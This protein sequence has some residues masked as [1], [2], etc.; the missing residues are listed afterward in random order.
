[1]KTSRR[2]FIKH[3]A[4][5]SAGLA[6][7]NLG[8]KISGK[9][10]ANVLGSNDRIRVGIVG[11]S[12]RARSTLIPAF[13]SFAEDL[14]FDLVAVS[15]IWKRR[16]D[17]GVEFISKKYGKTLAAARNNEELYEKYHPDAV[18]ISTADFQHAVH[19][20]EAVTASCDVYVE[21]P[22]A[23]TMEDNRAAL[24]AV[25]QSKQIVQIG[26][27]RRSGANYIRANEYIKSGEFGKITMVEMCWNVNEPGRWRRPE[28]V[29]D[30][31]EQDTDWK[32]YLINRPFE[33]WDPRKYVEYRLFW[34]YS[35][36]IPGQWMT[37]QI[38][39]VHWFSG[40]EFPR[41]VVASGGIYMWKDGRKNFDTMTAVFDYGLKDD[42]SD[43][44]QVVYSSRMHNSAGG[45]KEL[46]FSNGGTLNLD[47]NT[48]SPE[49]GLRE[50]EASAMGMKPNLLAGY[51]LPKTE[52]KTGADT[53]VDSLTLAHIRNWMEC[54]RERKKPNADI[55]AGYQHSIANIMTIAAVRTGKRAI[56]DE[57]RQEVLAGDEVFK[58]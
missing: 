10:F 39:T 1:M 9:G 25:R 18:I 16:R 47:T 40:Y 37:H 28:L 56:F 19:T 46:Y 4:L 51:T 57:D 5:G 49:G 29:K 54:V 50:R 3:V 23:E 17:E 53:G 44:F 27:Q 21:K 33:V 42:M 38:D 45:I 20:V 58:Y 11:F 7:G 31:R 22:F 48:I 12:D 52:V 26:T 8:A 15:D 41:S 35:S 14:N 24:N 6:L 13:F 2:D 55:E 32:R 36:G 30:L 43:G 34:P